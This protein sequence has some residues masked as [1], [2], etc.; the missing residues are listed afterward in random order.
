MYPPALT[1]GFPAP[2]GLERRALLHALENA[3]QRRR[4]RA[5]PV[6]VLLLSIDRF[7]LINGRLGFG[8]ADE[9]LHAV[10]RLCREIVGRRGKVGRF[11]AD[12]FLAVLDRTDR[13]GAVDL[14][15]RLRVAVES[16][17]IRTS[18]QPASVTASIG[19]ALYPDDADNAAT[20]LLAADEA[21][22]HARAAGRNRAVEAARVERHGL[23]MAS[24]LEAAL[25]ENRIVPA[26]QP[27]VDLHSGAI[28]GEEA[29]ARIV[30]TDG[31]AIEAEEFIDVAMQFQLTHRLDH[32]IALRLLQRASDTACLS[33][34]NVSADL[35]RRPHLL[36]DLLNRM[37]SACAR[38]DCTAH[39]IVIEVTERELLGNRGHVREHL[40]PFL[41][42][43]VKL[44]LDD[45]GSGYSSFQYLADFPVSFVKID[46]HLTQRLHE[47]KVATLVRG[48]GRIAHDLGVTTLAE[49]VETA[50]QAEALCDAGV[51]WG[52]G[53]Y[54]GKAVLDQAQAETC[55]RLSV[56]WAQGYY[57]R[58]PL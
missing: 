34:F 26:Y 17:V 38:R 37:Q 13:R 23:R 11:G 20:L 25:R 1:L 6:A 42:L 48:I 49:Y 41:A 22:E 18:R 55:R 30:T 31:A 10:A 43:G 45:F 16:A 27:I 40:A 9:V 58:E 12:E 47:P 24:T 56:N 4:K 32:C 15:E 7:K 35:L 46:G 21:L 28:V 29:L 44:A 3:I 52:Q 14:A 50:P 33:F 53:Y 39:P 57:Y 5:A 2:P 19:I 8:A 36:E 51:D 54:Y